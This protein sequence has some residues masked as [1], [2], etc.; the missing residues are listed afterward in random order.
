VQWYGEATSQV[1]LEGGLNWQNWRSKT[2]YSPGLIETR[3][4]QNTA[5][6]RTAASWRFRPHYSVVMEWRTTFNRE[7]ISLFQYNSHAL[8]LSLRWDNF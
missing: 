7:N 4:R 5:T 2:L 1:A 8:Q 6:L 3:R